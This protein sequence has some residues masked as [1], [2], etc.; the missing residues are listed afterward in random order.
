[1][2]HHREVLKLDPTR[3]DANLTVGLYGMP[4]GRCVDGQSTGRRGRLSWLKEKGLQLIELVTKEGRWSG[5][6]PRRIDVPHQGKTL[7][8]ALALAR[9]LMRSIAQ[10]LF[11]LEA[12]DAL[13]ARRNRTQEQNIEA[14]TKAERE[15]VCDFEDLLHDRSVRD[16]DRVRWITSNMASVADGRRGNGRQKSFSQPRR[17]TAQSRRV[18]MAHLYAARALI[19]RQTRGCIVAVSR[20]FDAA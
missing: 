6:M 18:T 20:S 1:M 15:G 11:R 13:V 14:A 19:G 3:I 16:T 8:D 7:P 4:W 12:A 9:E 10:Y 17:S 5:T 2:D